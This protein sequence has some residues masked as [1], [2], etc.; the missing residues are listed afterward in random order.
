MT[1]LSCHSHLDRRPIGINRTT[2]VEA[3]VVVDII[4]WVYLRPCSGKAA[5]WAKT[6]NYQVSDV[7]ADVGE[8]SKRTW[9]RGGI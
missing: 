3:L 2:D 4:V 9:H 8:N 1:K 7:K 6:R 5:R